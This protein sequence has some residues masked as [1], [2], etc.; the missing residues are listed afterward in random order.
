[1]K[2][3]LYDCP[4]YIHHLNACD[5]CL[6]AYCRQQ[7]KNKC[8]NQ[9]NWGFNNLRKKIAIARHLQ[10][11]STTSDTRVIKVEKTA[12][13]LYNFPIFDLCSRKL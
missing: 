5:K 10:M 12:Q 3:T 2:T 1:M 11:L 4:K 9:H 7:D 6:Y 8:W 13:W